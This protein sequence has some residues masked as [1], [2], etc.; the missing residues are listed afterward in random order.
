VILKALA[1]KLPG[2]EHWYLLTARE[3]DASSFYERNGFRPAGR[4]AA[5]VRP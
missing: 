5:F 1:D 4:L 3:S 2:V